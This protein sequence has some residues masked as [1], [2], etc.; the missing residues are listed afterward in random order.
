M[1]YSQRP[2]RDKKSRSTYNHEELRIPIPKDKVGLVIGRKGWRL[3]E[4]RERTGV[5]IS[6]KRDDQAH[7]R[8]TAEQCQNARKLIEEALAVSTRIHDSPGRGYPEGGGG[9]WL[10]SH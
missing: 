7:L 1:S 9:D 4:I 3:Q 6:M 10:K 8:G 2:R 5:Q